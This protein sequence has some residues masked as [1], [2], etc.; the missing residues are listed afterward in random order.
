MKSEHTE[1]SFESLLSRATSVLRRTRDS[2]LDTGPDCPPLARVTEAGSARLSRAELGHAADCPECQSRIAM[3]W[4]HRCPPVEL[5]RSAR[6]A[7]AVHEHLALDGCPVCVTRFL[8]SLEPTGIARWARSP[9]VLRSA[10]AAAAL[11]LVVFAATLVERPPSRADLTARL[12]ENEHLTALYEDLELV[13]AQ[14]LPVLAAVMSDLDREHRDL[15]SL[16]R[17]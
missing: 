1:T 5:L 10:V 14:P 17:P 3:A 11:A 13:N 6:R 16:L 15:V 12:L 2:S 9:R 8:R 7:R 4:R